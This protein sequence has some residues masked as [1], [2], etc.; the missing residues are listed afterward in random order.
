MV[1]R[2]GPPK[3][4]R[5]KTPIKRGENSGRYFRASRLFSALA[6]PPAWHLVKGSTAKKRKA[7]EAYGTKKKNSVPQKSF[8]KANEREGQRSPSTSSGEVVLTGDRKDPWQKQNKTG[9]G[10]KMKKST[11]DF[12]DQCEKPREVKASFN[13]QKKPESERLDISTAGNK[14]ME[15]KKTETESP[16]YRAVQ[17]KR[18]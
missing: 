7:S 16:L 3:T 6:E 18:D 14:K 12:T 5:N 15:E 13:I 11:E 9:K 4:G 2:E 10:N 8:S 17:S 1:V